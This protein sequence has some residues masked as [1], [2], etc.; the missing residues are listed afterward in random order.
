MGNRVCV[1]SEHINEGHVEMTAKS[2]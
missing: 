1:A 2:H